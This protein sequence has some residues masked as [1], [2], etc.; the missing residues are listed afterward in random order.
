MNQQALTFETSI[1]QSLRFNYLLYQPEEYKARQDWPLVL[2]LHGAGE[3]GDNLKLLTLH[4]LPKLVAAGQQF[5]FLIASPQCSEASWW[6]W[7]V[8]RLKVFL[9][10]LCE[11]YAVD[12]SRIYLTGLSMGGFGSWHLALR[13]PALFA[14]IAPICGG[15]EALPR[16]AERLIDLPVWAFHGDAD[17]LIPLAESERMVAAVN[18]AGGNARLTVYPGVGHNSWD[19]AYGEAELYTW[20][21]AQRRV[22]TS[23]QIPGAFIRQS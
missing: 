6:P 9:D 22:A 15:G 1:H 10:H 14:A 2:F 11:Q 20:F 4:G 13:Y 8:E 23:S 5:P 21:L 16:L 17:E 3:R 7:E 18:T 12:R 19:Q